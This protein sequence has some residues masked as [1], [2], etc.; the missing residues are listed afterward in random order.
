MSAARRPPPFAMQV[1]RLQTGITANAQILRAE[2]D[3]SVSKG[4]AVSARRKNA[5]PMTIALRKRSAPTGIVSS[6]TENKQPHHKKAAEFQPL[7]L[8]VIYTIETAR[9][10][11]KKTE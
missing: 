10:H 3:M 6:A 7:F 8:F 9:T 5:K 11:R 1:R 2:K 4:H